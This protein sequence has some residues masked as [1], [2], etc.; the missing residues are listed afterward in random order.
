[1]NIMKVIRVQCFQNL[2]NY[3]KPTS[4]LIKETY[5]LPPYSTV[6]GMIH[7]ACG[8]TEYHPMKL[9]IQGTNKGTV[10][11]L[12][13]RYSFA[14]DVRYEEGRHQICVPGVN[15]DYGVYKGIAYTELICENHMVFHILPREDDFDRV[16]QGLRFPQ[17]YVSLG[18]YED[19]L[20]IE[21]VECVDLHIAMEDVS[22]ANDMYI[23]LVNVR[24]REEEN[25]FDLE[26][27]NL[28][29]VV[30][31]VEVQL[32]EATIYMLNKEYEITKEG[33]RR[34]KKE[35]GKIQTYYVPK[36]QTLT[37]GLYDA[38]HKESVVLI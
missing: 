32:G 33:L 8:F 14:F 38:E 22:A 18:R 29:D 31:K 36:G 25:Q 23:P 7:A 15:T 13:T 10:P 5:P 12:Y 17:R 3:R 26:Q 28:G 34:W 11:D 21:A 37:H 19:I 20:D 24:T 27:G 30:F 2:S 1:M 35:G 16:L 9:S 6:L 4:F